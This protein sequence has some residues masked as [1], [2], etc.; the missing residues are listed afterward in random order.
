MPPPTIAAAPG[1]RPPRSSPPRCTPAQTKVGNRAPEVPFPF[2]PGPGRRR[3]LQ[4]R[5]HTL[6]R[7]LPWP[8]RLTS[9]PSGPRAKV[10]PSWPPLTL[11]LL[12][13][14][15]RASQRCHHGRRR[16]PP[17]ALVAGPPRTTPAQTTARDRPRRPPCSVSPSSRSLLWPRAAGRAP[18]M[19]A[20][21]TPLFPVE[22]GGRGW[23]FCQ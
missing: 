22:G 6:R 3:A 4:H 13:G 8:D 14:H 23:Q 21:F 20:P 15:P 10:G 7:P 9:S 19:A 1:R 5:S 17:P 2:P 11:L 16:S 12:P 18:P